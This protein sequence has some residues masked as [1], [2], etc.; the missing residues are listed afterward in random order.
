VSN[1][2]ELVRLS[3]AQFL[4]QWLLML[5]SGMELWAALPAQAT[6]AVRAVDRELTEPAS[7]G[8]AVDGGGVADN[9][10]ETSR[11]GSQLQEGLKVQ[12]ESRDDHARYQRELIRLDAHQIWLRRKQAGIEGD[13]VSDWVAAERR[14]YSSNR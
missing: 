3:S 8:E 13:P 11:E 7:S 1:F 6:Q 2:V 14:Y 12:R 9:N 10:N 4:A 5:R